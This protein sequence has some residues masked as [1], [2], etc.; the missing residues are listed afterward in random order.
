MPTRKIW[1]HV[2][3]MKK[4]FVLRKEKVYLLSREER[5]EV[6]EFI[7]EQLRKG[8]IRLSKLPQMASVFFVGKKNGKKRM[9]QNYRY[10]NEWTIKNNYLLPLIS[11][12]IENI[13]TKKI[14]TKMDLR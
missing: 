14:F 4:G 12:V 13:G 7:Q 3:D 10:L 5:E 1:D 6:C 8:Y 2:I 9:V 11:D